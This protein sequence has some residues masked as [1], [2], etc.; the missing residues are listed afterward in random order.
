MLEYKPVYS[1]KEEEDKAMTTDETRDIKNRFK[2]L[3]YTDMSFDQIKMYNQYLQLS[4]VTKK[5]YIPPPVNPV[6]QK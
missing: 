3:K 2:E 6:R 5:P 4:G 1:S